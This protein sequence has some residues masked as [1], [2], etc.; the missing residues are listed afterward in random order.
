MKRRITNAKAR[1]D[2]MAGHLFLTPSYILT[3]AFVIA[4]LIY[5]IY[6]GF[7]KYNG[8]SQM[9]WIGLENYIKLFKDDKF[10]TAMKNSLV[11]AALTVPS[12]IVFSLAVS[13][14]LAGKFRNKFGQA[15][16]IILY[17][18]TM[19]SLV[20][21][22]SIFFFIFASGED[23]IVN[24]VLGWFGIPRQNW[25]GQRSTAMP[26]VAF[27]F[28]WKNLGYQVVYF[29]AGIM[30]IPRD[31]YEAARLDGA[32]FM[33][34]FRYITLPTLK[35]ILYMVLV[36][37]ILGAFQAFD[38]PYAMTAGGP[39]NATLLPGYHIYLYAFQSRRMGYASAYAL[40]LGIF[41]FAVNMIA[42]RVMREKV[43]ENDG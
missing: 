14:I 31:Y 25:L 42:R 23:G 24:T 19:V 26:V 12:L 11:Y 1:R 7:C 18:P 39:G 38:I 21:V 20:L 33:Q 4:P 34:Q 17:L 6:L 27:V 2:A 9:K 13:A 10:W 37:L 15:T 16:R 5:A 43:G 8:F 22:A 3:I 30:D 41:T 29:Y 36:N 28:L 35:P 32:S 40:I